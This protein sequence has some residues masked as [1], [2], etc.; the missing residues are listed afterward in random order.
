MKTQD[1]SDKSSLGKYQ[2]ITHTHTY[3]QQKKNHIEIVL[4]ICFTNK[5]EASK[6]NYY[7]EI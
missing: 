2:I 7:S 5:S 3:K 6:V 4:T 1:S